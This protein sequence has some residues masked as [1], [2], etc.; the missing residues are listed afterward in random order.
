MINLFKC[1]DKVY[2]STARLNKIANF[3]LRTA[4]IL[5]IFFSMNVLIFQNL[6][7]LKKVTVT[8][9]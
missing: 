6:I 2:I 8:V 9:L 3:G 5:S 1:G 7:T 4:Q